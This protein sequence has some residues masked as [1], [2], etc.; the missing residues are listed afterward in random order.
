MIV[1]LKKSSY[2]HKVIKGRRSMNR[3]DVICDERG[4]IFKKE[5]VPN[6]FV[7]HFQQFLGN[8]SDIAVLDD[9]GLFST[10]L[11][12]DEAEDMIRVVSNKEIKDA[13]FYIG[14]HRALG[15]DGW[16]VLNYTYHFPFETDLN[17]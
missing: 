2:F 3:V 1:A 10:M 12:Q 4:D 9:E 15:P 13:M 14:D 5:E 6:Q 17:D 11:N 8:K 16:Y 7:K